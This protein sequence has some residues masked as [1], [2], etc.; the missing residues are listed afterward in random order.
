MNIQNYFFSKSFGG[1]SSTSP[2]NNDLV[3]LAEEA[4]ERV[5]DDEIEDEE[6]ESEVFLLE[7]SNS[8]NKYLNLIFIGY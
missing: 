4:E 7:N 2:T 8:E 5:D 1:L 6:S 3:E